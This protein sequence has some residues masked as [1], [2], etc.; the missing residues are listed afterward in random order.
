MPVR[1]YL[2]AGL[3]SQLANA[4]FRPSRKRVRG[5]CHTI[6]PYF[7]ATAVPSQPAS[8]RRLGFHSNAVPGR[9]SSDRSSA[10]SVFRQEGEALCDYLTHA[11][12]TLTQLA[13]RND[14]HTR[15]TR[16]SRLQ[17]EQALT[18]DVCTA[19]RIE[20]LC[21]RREFM[22]AKFEIPLHLN[23]ACDIIQLPC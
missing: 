10:S 14:R 2:G 15:T 17:A 11:S 13:N 22:Y 23:G 9:R 21:T 5:E 16:V 7:A 6:P 3:A 12:R 1:I 8:E 19:D 4:H 20:H 18:T